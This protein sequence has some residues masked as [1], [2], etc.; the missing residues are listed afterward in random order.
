MVRLVQGAPAPLTQANRPL[1]QPFAR[2]SG[3][4]ASSVAGHGLETPKEC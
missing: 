1:D 4:L 3:G 2:I